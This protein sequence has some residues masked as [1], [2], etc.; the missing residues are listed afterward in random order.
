MFFTSVLFVG[1]GYAAHFLLEHAASVSIATPE[2]GDTALHLISICSPETT[3]EETVSA[4]TSVA[5]RLL[6]RGL[7][8]NL[9]NKK[10]L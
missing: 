4:M 6:D 1:D 10:G 8:P 5:K 9:Q 2:R 7:D 3:S